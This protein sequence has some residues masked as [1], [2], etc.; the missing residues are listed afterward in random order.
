MKECQFWIST[1]ESYFPPSLCFFEVFAELCKWH[2]VQDAKDP[3][4]VQAGP[5]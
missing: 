4:S 3:L 2:G 5:G 1:F